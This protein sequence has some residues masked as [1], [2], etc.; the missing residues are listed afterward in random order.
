MDIETSHQDLLEYQHNEIEYWHRLYH[1]PNG[2]VIDPEMKKIGPYAAFKIPG[3]DILAYNRTLTE[4]GSMDD[5]TGYLREVIE[6]YRNSSVPRFFIMIN[7]GVNTPEVRRL[8]SVN[9]FMHYNDWTRFSR[10]T[11]MPLPDIPDHLQVIPVERSQAGL[12]ARTIVNSFDIPEKLFPL[13]KATVGAP[14]YRQYL[15]MEKNRAIAAGALFTRNGYASLAIA[16]T[17]PA[18][19]GKGAQSALISMRIL[20][21]RKLGCERITVETSRETADKK[22]ASYRNMVRFG[23]RVVH[24]RPNYIYYSS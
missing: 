18:H 13:F 16:G 21:A 22:V 7:E 23:F 24:H 10:K 12:Y 3:I 20:E 17:L 15:V 9:G 2:S 4:T 19:R 1:K 11:M 6:F 14:G 8:L 5:Y